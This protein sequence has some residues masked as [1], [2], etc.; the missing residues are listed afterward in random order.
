[1]GLVI[2]S[3]TDRKGVAITVILI[4]FLIVTA[5]GNIGSR[6]STTMSGAGT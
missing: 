5:I 3:F 2:S 1:M 6:C 4:G